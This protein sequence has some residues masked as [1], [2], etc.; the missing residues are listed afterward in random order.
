MA[1][2]GHDEEGAPA[3]TSDPYLTPD[4]AADVK[5]AKHQRNLAFMGTCSN[6]QTSESLRVQAHETLTMHHVSKSAEGLSSCLGN[7]SNMT[8]NQ[9]L[10]VMAFSGHSWSVLMFCVP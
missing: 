7:G 9:L 6:P 2:D 3:A 10:R 8:T 5:P 1:D 4:S